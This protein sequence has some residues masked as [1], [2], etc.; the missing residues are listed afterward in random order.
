MDLEIKWQSSKEWFLEETL[1]PLISTWKV[2]SK[3]RGRPFAWDNY[4]PYI[5][6]ICSFQSE[7][8]LDLN[9]RIFIKSGINFPGVLRFVSRPRDRKIWL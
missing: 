5:M 6:K 2:F 9:N 8:T 7:Q 4:A 3:V 1:N